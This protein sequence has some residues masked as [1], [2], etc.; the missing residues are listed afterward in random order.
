MLYLTSQTTTEYPSVET[1]LTH[2]E[3]F[4]AFSK[5]MII[6][7]TTI[8]WNPYS[9]DLWTNQVHYSIIVVRLFVL[10]I[11]FPNHLSITSDLFFGNTSAELIVFLSIRID[12]F[13]TKTQIQIKIKFSHC[14]ANHF[15]W[16]NMSSNH[17]HFSPLPNWIENNEYLHYFSLLN[18]ITVNLFIYRFS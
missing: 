5:W 13:W 4:Y 15:P 12:S 2:L 14:S 8:W 1:P 9:I 6:D 18:E 11:L 3:V 10:F 7:S 17:S 16:R